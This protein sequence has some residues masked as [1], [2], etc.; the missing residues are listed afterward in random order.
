MNLNNIEDIYRLSPMQQGMLFHTIYASGSNVY[1]TQFCC[2]LKGQLDVQHLE[3]AW[4]QTVN[5]H[6]TLRTSF[7]WEGLDEPVQVVSRQVNMPLTQHDWRALSETEQRERLEEF[8]RT[9]R[10][11]GFELSKAPL[12]RLALFQL[13][14]DTFHLV[15][16]CHHI[17]MDGWSLGLLIREVFVFYEA[18]RYEQQPA[19]DPVRPYRDYIAWLQRQSM[20]DA[21]AYWRK[22]LKDFTAPTPL[23][24]DRPGTLAPDAESVFDEQRAVLST[25]TTAALQSLARQHQLTLNT[26][27]QGAWAVLLNRYSGSDDVVFG[28]TVSGRPPELEGVET[29]IGLFINTLPVRVRVM[30]EESLL[31]W[32]K[33]LQEQQV[34][35]RQY[36][37]SPLVQV[38][39]WSDVPRGLPLFESILA[40]E[41]FPTGGPTANRKPTL[42]RSEGRVIERNNYPIAL[43]VSSGSELYLRISYDC[44]RFNAETITRTLDHLRSVLERISQG[45]EQNLSALSPL[46]EAERHRFVVEWNQTAAE[47]PKETCIHTLFEQQVEETPEAFAAEFEGEQLTY[48]ELNARANQLAH[49]LRS[50]GVAP[51]VRVG[52]CLEHSLETLIALLG[53]LKAGGVYVPLEP[54]H[55]KAKLAFVLTDA[56]IPVLLTQERLVE[57]LPETGAKI[58]CLDSGWSE[59]AGAS[60]EN[61]RDVV[62]AIDTAYVIYTSGSTGQPKGVKIQHA[63]L[64]NY[65]WWARDVY[66]Q[67]EKLDFPLYSSLAFDLTITSIYTPLITGNKVVVYRNAN[68]EL[69]LFAVMRDNKVGVLKLTPSHLSMIKENDNSRSNIKRLIVGGEAFESKLAGEIHRSFGGRVEIFNEYGPTEATVGCMIHKFDPERDTRLMVP[70]GI[71]AANT[72]IYV[73]D[74]QL[75]PVA[76]NVVGELY[77]AGDGLTEGYLNREEL[78]RERCIENPFTP[79]KRMYKSG[80][81]ARRLPDGGLELLGRRDDQVK[82][83]GHRVELNEIRSNLNKHPQV[84][85]SIA[86]VTK[87]KNG[88]DVMIA[89]YVS[90]QELE[91]A[92]LRSFLAEHIVEET[93]P[94]IFAHLRKLPLTLNGKVNLQALPTLAEI[95]QTQHRVFDAPRTDI[96]KILAGIWAHALNVEQVGA[97][98]NFFELGGHSLIATQLISRVRE[99]FGI[100]VQ[101]SALFESPTVAGLA[102]KIE[103]IRSA[104]RHVTTPP[105]ERVSRDG[106]MPLSYAQERLWFL[107]QLNPGNTSYNIHKSIRLHGQLD[108]GAL[109]QTL[110]EIVRRHESLR[111]SFPARNGTPVQV[112]APAQPF[113]LEVVEL[114]SFAPDERELRAHQ[115]ATEEGSRPFDLSR[116]PMLRA[117]VLRL[118]ADEHVL[119][120]TM[121]HIVSDAWSMGVLVREVTALYQAIS[122]GQSPALPELPIQYADFAHWQRGWLQGEVGETHL[123]YW[124]GQLARLPRMLEFP[125]DHPRPPVQS[126]HGAFHAQT[127][128]KEMTGALKALSNKQ[129]VTLFMTLL[130]AYHIVLGHYSNRDEIP[131]GI[132][133]ANRNRVE[134]EGLI[135]LF[136]NQV[137]LL[138]DR[139]GDL[140]FREFL[141]RVRELSLAGYAHQDLP[142]DR[143]VEALNPERVLS[144]N[145][146]FQVMFGFQNTS[147]STLELPGLKLSG[148]DVGGERSVF[149]LSLYMVEK[150]QG[151]I[152]TWAYRTSLFESSTIVRFAEYFELLLN[153]IV[154]DTEVSLKALRELLVNADREREQAKLEKFKEARR[155]RLKNVNERFQPIV[156]SQPARDLTPGI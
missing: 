155:R 116:D 108:I 124:T 30:P 140:C 114:E 4:Q 118:G 19:L 21:E 47:Y 82:F 46:T 56:A 83:H 93:I 90:R 95:K 121:H 130:S 69:P 23:A 113:K 70:I 31:S 100:D 151:L 52:L 29:I 59:I 13:S 154:N 156:E 123:R 119:L 137:V 41:N 3:R 26:I 105:I 141:E 78:T 71:P 104:E 153:R 6:P 18:A 17:L 63:A 72:Q 58:I 102:A 65:I 12:M 99:A 125:T 24:T 33:R 74:E 22:T 36:E 85:D 143:L 110:T 40:F 75:N 107:D 8:I 27:V 111:T 39:Q 45:L 89:Y 66:L 80:D 97:H 131:I 147:T 35:M 106:E 51:G 5:R 60:V 32:L 128:S 146:L 126:Y 43:V 152:G 62:K 94:N 88:N 135:G 91:A 73:L 16:S 138:I 9:D 87:D 101:L 84:R 20:T 81:L 136:V 149:E 115:L 7:M 57:R 55:P 145:P 133:V 148:A 67:N 92:Q 44:A 25:E 64:T 86:V 34:E 77:I 127:F 144:H 14:D 117:R 134:T 15:W 10:Q 49:H 11:R 76:E 54:A 2:T 139:S 132:D 28:A 103:A 109:E 50:L 112:V 150:E 122:N 96:E 120:F 61:P 79:G 68:R 42:E 53:T 48:A 142:F 129:G 38:Q 37:F 1:F 98:D